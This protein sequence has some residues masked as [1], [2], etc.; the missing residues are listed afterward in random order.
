[1]STAFTLA[2][3]W[4]MHGDVGAG[5]MVG[6]MGLMVLFWAA[7][8]F[9]VVWVARGGRRDSSTRS[10]LGR[11]ESPIEILDRR[12]AEGAIDEA[13]YRTRRRVL[14]G[15]AREADA[16]GTDRPLPGS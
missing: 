2:D 9:G 1:V 14:A 5:W 10:D 6:M 16:A 11:A 12:F 4:G 15:G 7:V 8:I 13:D 3:T